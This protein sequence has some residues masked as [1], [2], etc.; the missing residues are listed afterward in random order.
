ML[1]NYATVDRGL[2]HV[3][4]GAWQSLSVILIPSRTIL[5][6]FAVIEAGGVE[7]GEYTVVFE[8]FN[9]SGAMRATASFVL[10]VEEEGD[11]A[12]VPCA[13]GLEVEVDELGIWRCAARSD[14]GPLGAVD[15]MIKQPDSA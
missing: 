15:V 2:V 12:R 4:N 10:A 11:L 1:A 3:V 14:H 8:A 7:M 9:P 6:V 5:P 13:V